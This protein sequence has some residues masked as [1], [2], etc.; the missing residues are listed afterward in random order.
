MTKI[1]YN[2]IVLGI[3]LPSSLVASEFI[4][5]PSTYGELRY[6]SGEWSMR[7]SSSF[8]DPRLVLVR[9]D[10]PY[11]EVL[12]FLGRSY[13]PDNC[14]TTQ[15]GFLSCL[16]HSIHLSFDPNTQLL[17]YSIFHGGFLRSGD[18][19]QDYSAVSLT[20]YSCTKI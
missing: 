19:A 8:S 17:N 3:F 6:H 4:C 15:D 7:S 16:D 13:G 10:E 2:S 9:P 5:Q 11:M 12:G 20:L 1:L 18:E 14:L